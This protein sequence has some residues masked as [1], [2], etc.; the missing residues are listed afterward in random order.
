MDRRKFI[1]VV[2]IGIALVAVPF[3]FRALDYGQSDDYIREF[4]GKRKIIR[5]IV[6]ASQ[7]R[8]N[9]IRVQYCRFR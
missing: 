4:E 9:T 8:Y 6:F 7:I 2:L 1:I 3:I 5:C